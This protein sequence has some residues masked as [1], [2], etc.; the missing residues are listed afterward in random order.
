MFSPIILVRDRNTHYR[1]Q[2]W[3]RRR[4]RHRLLCQIHN[5][6]TQNK[7]LHYLYLHNSA[8][9][10]LLEYVHTSIP[11]HIFERDQLTTLDTYN[12]TSVQQH[13]AVHLQQQFL[14]ISLSRP[15]TP[16]DCENDVLIL[17][18][19]SCIHVSAPPPTTRSI[20]ST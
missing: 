20:A 16:L 2:A 14:S 13:S 4:V 15:S 7:H 19:L 8:L 9:E 18:R 1:A 5:T 6:N 3:R 12:P 17:P 10:F 11:Y